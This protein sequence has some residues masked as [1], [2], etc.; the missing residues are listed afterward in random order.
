MHRCYKYANTSM[1]FLWL[2]VRMIFS[3]VRRP[4]TLIR[5][6]LRAKFCL[7]AQR[8]FSLEQANTDELSKY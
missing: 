4:V 1:G 7:F 3:R 5:S 8:E 2:F 6:F